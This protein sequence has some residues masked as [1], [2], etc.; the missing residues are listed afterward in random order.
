MSA[1]TWPATMKA[2]GTFSSQIRSPCRR[3]NLATCLVYAFRH[4]GKCLRFRKGYVSSS[5]PGSKRSSA[6]ADTPILRPRIAC[7]DL[8]PVVRRDPEFGACFGHSVDSGCGHSEFGLGVSCGGCHCVNL[9][10]GK[11]QQLRGCLKV[12]RV[13]TPCEGIAG[14]HEKAVFFHHMNA[15]RNGQQ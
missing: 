7:D 13:V 6:A 5:S 2:E 14:L 12:G 15:F 8:G 4:P 1:W 9:P 3:S 10:S 11:W